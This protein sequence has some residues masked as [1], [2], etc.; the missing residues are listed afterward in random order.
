MFTMDDGIQF[1][2]GQLEH[3]E[4][5]IFEVKYGL[6]TVFRNIPMSDEAGPEADS[7]SYTYI[8]RQG[9]AK[10]I[11]SESYDVPM[12]TFSEKKKTV[13]I[14]LGGIG[15]SY[16]LDELRKSQRL[17]RDLS[18]QKG[19]SARRAYEDHVQEVGY[20]G[21]S[22]RDLPGFLDN[23]NVPQANVVGG[24]WTTKTGDE[25]LADINGALTAQFSI[26]KER[27]LADTMLLPSAQFA[28]I[29]SRRIVDINMTILQY[30]MLNNVYTAVTGLPFNIRTVSDLQGRGVGATDR[31]LFYTNT[32]EKVIMHVPMPLE[33]LPA[34]PKVLGFLIPGQYKLGGVEFRYPL[35]ASYLD[36]I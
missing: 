23:P 10:F 33:F 12:A 17:N 8:D 2:Q 27:E 30:L 21:D 35:S 11:E 7:V 28:D 9:M 6:I 34:Q 14:H 25:I 18:T 26:T 15:Y 1:L 16:S 24:V 32:P 19:I 5:R 29:A 22:E 36:G 4:R 31:A 3:I 20:N 13:P